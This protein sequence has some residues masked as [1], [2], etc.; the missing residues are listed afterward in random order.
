M[1]IHF[2]LTLEYPCHNWRL[3]R[4]SCWNFSL[5]SFY[6]TVSYLTLGH[7]GRLCTDQFNKTTAVKYLNV[8]NFNFSTVSFQLVSF[9]HDSSVSKLWETL[10]YWELCL[11]M[12][13]AQPYPIRPIVSSLYDDRI[14]FSVLQ[15]VIETF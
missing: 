14:R 10:C 15:V 5:R 3:D 9:S 4:N 11:K 7:F 12:H 13:Q 8:M 6:E 2:Y 1:R